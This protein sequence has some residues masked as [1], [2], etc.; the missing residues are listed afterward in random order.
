VEDKN[1]TLVDAC[2]NQ[3]GTLPTDSLH[4][5]NDEAA[6]AIG[7]EAEFLALE[8][9]DI[10]QRLSGIRTG[11]SSDDAPG[12]LG[13]DTGSTENG[14]MH[15]EMPT[16]NRTEK[17]SEGG[18]LIVTR[19]T[20][21][22]LWYQCPPLVRVAKLLG[23]T[24]QTHSALNQ[25]ERYAVTFDIGRD[26]F[27]LIALFAGIGNKSLEPEQ[28]IAMS[29]WDFVDG[30]LRLCD[31]VGKP[32]NIAR[33]LLCRSRQQMLERLKTSDLVRCGSEDN[34]VQT[35]ESAEK[36]R[37]VTTAVSDALA[38][39]VADVNREARRFREKLD[40]I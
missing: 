4:R 36:S 7:W 3:C 33:L 26:L 17:E 31:F 20:F 38:G 35:Q 40:M 25:E 28:N 30:Y 22:K 9:R 29:E 23:W 1:W 14:M 8:L 6:R 15:L 5:Q 11:E 2:V 18:T 10:L 39:V 12:N 37:G 16:Q 19:D 32:S 13:A 34:P 21:E 24:S 27:E